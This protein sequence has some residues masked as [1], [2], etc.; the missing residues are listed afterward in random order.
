MVAGEGCFSMPGPSVG[1]PGT[2][3]FSVHCCPSSLLSKCAVVL[4]VGV[5]IINY[6]VSTGSVVCV[7]EFYRL[8]V[9]GGFLQEALFLGSECIVRAK[10]KR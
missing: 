2:R 1:E 9:N 6:V 10:C 3:E 5:I 7:A 4:L 8:S